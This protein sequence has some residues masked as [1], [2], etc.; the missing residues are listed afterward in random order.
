[1]SLLTTTFTDAAERGKAFGIYGAIAGSGASVGL[2]LGGVL[3]QTLNWR[4]SMYVN[5]VFAVVAII[6]ALSL[7]HNQ[8]WAG[9]GSKPK[10]DI[11]G[12]LTVS[13]GLFA[14]VYGFN[15]AQTTSWSN[16]LTIGMLATGVL[17]LM[18]FAW[19]QSRVRNPLLPLKVVADRNRGAS[20]LAI[21]ISG[22]AM[23]GVFLFLTYYLQQSRGYSPIST[24]LA[25]LPMTLAVMVTAVTTN[26]K[27]RGRFS[28][29]SLVTLGMGLGAVGMVGLT[30]L[31]LTS[32]YAG[33]IL[34]WLAAMGVGMGLIFGTAMNNATLGV[35][36]TDAGVASAM[37][38]ASQQVGG[39]L[40]TAL[41][42]TL[43][44]SAATSFVTSNAVGRPTHALLAHAAMHGYTTAFAVAA[45]M[46]AIGGLVSA[47]VYERGVKA[48][49]TNGAPVM[50]H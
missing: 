36:A 48:P 42:S 15:H 44:A 19:L 14:I 50:A 40:G 10:I 34:P 12:V 3:T 49:Q 38:S 7:L 13:T 16:Q 24:G 39:S 28:P 9:S 6:G 30:Q 18:V 5:L 43:A 41:L 31:T 22:A 45:G 23:F 25:F 35:Q 33:A 47:L 2:L 29:R 32:G 46:F 26:T 37:V 8:G 4:F 11:P 27:L 1:M 21:G 20:F 17:L